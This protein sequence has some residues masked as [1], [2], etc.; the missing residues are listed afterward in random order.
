MFS[1]MGPIECRFSS[2]CASNFYLFKIVKMFLKALVEGT[3]CLAY[4]LLLAIGAGEFVNAAFFVLTLGVGTV[5]F[6]G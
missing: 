5:W 3:F 6:H 2:K 1:L 4:V